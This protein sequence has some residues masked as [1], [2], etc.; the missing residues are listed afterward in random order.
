MYLIIM[1]RCIACQFSS[2][3]VCSNVYVGGGQT[4]ICRSWVSIGNAMWSFTSRLLQAH[5][6]Q[7]FLAA[8]LSSQKLLH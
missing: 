6:S 8:E 4:H 5:L 3:T 1:Q 7:S 2:M